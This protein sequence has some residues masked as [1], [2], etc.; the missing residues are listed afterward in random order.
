MKRT[1]RVTVSEPLYGTSIEVYANYSQTVALRRCAKLMGLDANDPAN[2]PDESAAGWCMSHE[3]TAVIWID[4][5]PADQ[6][7]LPHELWHAIHGFL[8]HIESGD[9]ETGAYLVGHYD[10]RIRA[11]LDKK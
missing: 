7:S 8:R 10:P 4:D 1:R 9:E 5:Y 3:G 2:K 6:S 11:K